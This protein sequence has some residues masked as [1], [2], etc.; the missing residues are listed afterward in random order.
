MAEGVSGLPEPLRAILSLYAG[1]G[2]TL[3]DVAGTLGL[4][5]PAVKDPLI[6]CQFAVAL[7]PTAGLVRIASSRNCVARQLVHFQDWLNA[8]L[9]RLRTSPLRRKIYKHI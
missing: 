9:N 8:F 5:L 2:L 3:E 4:S 6:P 1:S 7:P